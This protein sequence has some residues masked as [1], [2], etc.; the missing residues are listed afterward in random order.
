MMTERL[1]I[2]A[3][4]VTLVASLG[5]CEMA[6]NT[7]DRV[8]SVWDKPL[9]YDCPDYRILKDAAR[10]TEFKAGPGRDLVDVSVEASI[11]DAALECLTFVDSKTKTGYMEAQFTVALAA[12]RGPANKTKRATLPYFVSVTDK[13]RAV[14]YRETFKI[15]V[16]F[17]DNRNMV[18]TW[19][20][21]IKLELPLRPDITSKDYVIFTGF[22]L[23]RTQLEYNRAQQ[24]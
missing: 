5:G 4:T 12:R 9:V 10:L 13:N 7:F 1:R 15:A 11:P 20:E 6:T 17:S 18:Q 21:L 2:F 16:R 3:I 8:T 14:L 23:N 19:G 22:A 24:W